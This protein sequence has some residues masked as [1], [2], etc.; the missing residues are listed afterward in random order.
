MARMDHLRRVE[1]DNVAALRGWLSS[2]HRQRE[3]IWLVTYKKVAGARYVSASDV[4]DEAL[5]FGWIDSLPRKLDAT[6]TMLLLSPRKEGSAWSAVNKQKVAKLQAEGRMQPS[7]LAAVARAKADGSWD[8]LN[9]VDAL[10]EPADLTAALD[11]D[12]LARAGWD[13]LARSMRRGLL[14]QVKQAKKADTRATRITKI[15]DMV[16]ED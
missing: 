3:S 1:V 5:C 2:N 13:N 4:V 9:D 6:R 7:G 10:I 15:I 11:A 12:P 8:F 16:G 14:E